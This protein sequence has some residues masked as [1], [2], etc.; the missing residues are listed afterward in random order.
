MTVYDVELA[1]ESIRAIAADDEEAHI[2]EDNLYQQVLT[3]IAERRTDDPSGIAAA[4][5]KTRAIE[6]SRW[7]A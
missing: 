7:C 6:F 5:L 1:V 3:A 4:A 2:R